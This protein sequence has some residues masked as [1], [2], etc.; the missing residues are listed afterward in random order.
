MPTEMKFPKG[1]R[2]NA[3]HRN[4]SVFIGTKEIPMVACDQRQDNGEF[5]F[6]GWRPANMKENKVYASGTLVTLS[7]AL[8]EDFRNREVSVRENNGYFEAFI[9]TARRG[10][11]RENEIR[12]FVADTVETATNGMKRDVSWKVTLGGPDD[13]TADVLSIVGNLKGAGGGRTK[14]EAADTE[15]DF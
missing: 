8:T 15:D 5:V 9:P 1:Y 6:V 12:Q 3:D 14:K 11:Q 2:Q 13:R 10:D 7:E 4:V